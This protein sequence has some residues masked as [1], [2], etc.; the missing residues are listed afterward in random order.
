MAAPHTQKT[1]D[2]VLDAAELLFAE[3]GIRA[4]S[5]RA[6][7][8]EAGV[9][10]AAVHYHFG[11]KEGLLDA[12]IERQALP[13]NESRLVE[14]ERLEREAGDASPT[15]EA[16]LAAFILPA[17]TRLR[18]LG[19]RA[20]HLPRLLARIEA[21][22][23]DVV[24]ALMRKHFGDV[25]RRFVE[26]LHRALPEHSQETV[27]ERLRFTA[28]LVSHLFSGNFDLD[29]IPGHPPR[30]QDPLEQIG[31][32]LYFLA[33]GMRAPDPRRLERGAA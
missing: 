1:R 4:T 19:P 13:V 26:A 10:L 23:T 29:V 20:Q 15:A 14:L 3:Q 31:H 9:N 6:I 7:T 18:D 17:V 27:T 32:A 30:P 5:L 24:E 8:R 33:A 12:V 21:Q 2:R 16:L 22:P 28:G 25:A 11:S